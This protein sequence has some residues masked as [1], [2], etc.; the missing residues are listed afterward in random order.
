MPKTYTKDGI[1]A[2]V[3]IAFGQGTG[4]VRV[5][6]E[7]ALRVG[8]CY[9]DIFEANKDDILATWETQGVQALERVRAVGRAA[10]SLI[11]AQGRTVIEAK[12]L[13][14]ALNTSAEYQHTNW[15]P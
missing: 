4:S 5:S 3:Y 2:Q 6:H 11:N 10:A 9:S 14:K 7:A 15:C 13:E 12:D 8:E 1:I